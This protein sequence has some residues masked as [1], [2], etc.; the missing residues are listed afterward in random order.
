AAQKEVNALITRY[1]ELQAQICA[2]SPR[3]AGLTQ[4]AP[5]DLKE[6]QQQ[7]LDDDTLMLEYS[8]GKE[9]SFLWAVTTK[10]IASFELPGR[11]KIE[12]AAGRVYT[13]LTMSHTRQRKRESERAA[14][15]LSRMLLE[16]VAD[17]L[18]KKRLLI[19]ADGAL[20]YI[21]FAALSVFHTPL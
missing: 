7:L 18:E 17:Q 10:S 15:E 6:I 12:A 11:E 2:T 16:P 14:A 13:L 4:P 21:P 20:Q 1:K 8:L 5:L 9:R 19:V 3:Y